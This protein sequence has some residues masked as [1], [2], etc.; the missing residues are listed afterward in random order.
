MG[1]SGSE[2]PCAVRRW[3]IRADCPWNVSDAPFDFGETLSRDWAG[4]RT[5][6]IR[7]GITPTASYVAQFLG[8]PSGGQSTGFTY[9]EDLRA[10]RALGHR[11]AAAGRRPLPGRRNRLV[12]GTEPVGRRDR[13]HLRRAERLHGRRRRHEQPDTRSPVPAPATARRPAD[14]RGRTARARRDLRHDAGAEQLRQRRHQRDTRVAGDGH[15]ELRR[16][17]RRGCSGAHRP[18]TA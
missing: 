2:D 3:P 8:N 14:A 16:V 11:Q 13:Q 7:L 18:S 4:F 10:A 9:T 6:L 1:P 12:H 17:T 15:P 5:E